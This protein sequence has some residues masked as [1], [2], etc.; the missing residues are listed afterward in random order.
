MLSSYQAESEI[1]RT[2]AIIKELA[3]RQTNNSSTNDV[4]S[5]TIHQTQNANSTNTEVA[6]A[7]RII[8][9]TESTKVTRT[10]QKKYVI[11]M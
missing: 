6:I 3:N 4:I 10:D 1:L 2:V 7:D 11:F 5:L 9:N 8:T